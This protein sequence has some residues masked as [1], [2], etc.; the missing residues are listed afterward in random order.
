MAMLA[1]LGL[2]SVAAVWWLYE[3][4]KQTAAQ[5]KGT[6]TGGG[7]SGGGSSSGGGVIGG[8]Q[9][10]DPVGPPTAGGRI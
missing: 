10:G 4:H 9:A 3:Q 7:S 6:G 2:V 5:A 8:Q 1:L